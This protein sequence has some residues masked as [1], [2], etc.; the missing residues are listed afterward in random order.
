MAKSWGF[1]TNHAH[2]LI[3]IARD[4]RS[5][6]R[7]IANAAGITERATHSV[8]GDLREGGIVH[9]TRDGRNNVYS[10]DIQTLIKGERW[11]ASDMEIPQSLI[12]ATLRGLA[13]VATGIPA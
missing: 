1:L 6:V 10:I 7:E 9:A 13:G 4:P 12:D 11:S 3:Q 2:V 8:L 5:T